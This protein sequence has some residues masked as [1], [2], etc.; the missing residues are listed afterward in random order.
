[1]KINLFKTQGNP[2]VPSGSEKRRKTL[3]DSQKQQDILIHDDSA[4]LLGLEP[5]FYSNILGNEDKPPVFVGR[6]RRGVAYLKCFLDGMQQDM[7]YD[8]DCSELLGKDEQ[9]SIQK[10]K[11]P[12]MLGDDVNHEEWFIRIFEKD[13]DGTLGRMRTEIQTGMSVTDHGA[14]RGVSALDSINN[15]VNYDKQRIS[16]ALPHLLIDSKGSYEYK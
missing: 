2:D 9:Y 5:Y 12:I 16:G 7:F 6:D 1:M 15:R 14:G 8:L 4:K 3:L 10:I 11:Q 13:P